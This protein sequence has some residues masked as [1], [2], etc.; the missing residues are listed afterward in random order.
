MKQMKQ[1]IYNFKRLPEPQK[2]A[3]LATISLVLAAVYIV[4]R[5]RKGIV[6][7]AKKYEGKKEIPGNMGFPDKVMESEMRKIG[8]YPGAEWCAFFVKMAM[9]KTLSNL[10]LF[11]K[12]RTIA[13]KLLSGSSQQTFI[14]FQ[15]DKSG[16]WEISTNKPKVG[17]IVIWQ[18]IGNPS[19]GHAGIVTKVNS[20]NFETIEGNV[21]LSSTNI[22]S[23]GEVSQRKY[24]I[25][26]ELNGNE[27]G[28]KL[29]GFINPK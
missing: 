3:I 24:S 28:C 2:I 29:R 9:L 17:A 27:W 19:K 4:W 1:L 25:S 22:P 5:N 6:G 26:K 8:W 20:D 15:N 12:R 11:N 21:N 7:V 13:E 18:Q 16:L 23:D 14:N 10:P